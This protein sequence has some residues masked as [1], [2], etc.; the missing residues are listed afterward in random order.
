MDDLT[1]RKFG[2]L[3][4]IQ[5]EYM[6]NRKS[7]LLCKCQCGN[8]KVIRRDALMSGRVKSCG[9]FNRERARETRTVLNLKHG[10]SNTRLYSIWES[11]KKRCYNPKHK[12]YNRYGGRGII[13]CEGW[14]HDF[15]AFYDW[16]ITHGY[17]D[18]LTIDRIN[19][20]GIYEPNNCRWITIQEQQRNKG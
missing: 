19:N 17:E 11:M 20:N 2:R 14:L 10:K 1:K 4:V 7:H 8:Y 3:E 13:V 12:N 5:F 18:C 6:K 16:A 15:Q 9:C